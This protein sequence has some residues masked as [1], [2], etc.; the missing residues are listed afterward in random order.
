MSTLQT[1]EYCTVEWLWNDSNIRVTRPIQ[2]DDFQKGSYAEVV[3]TLTQLGSEGWEV[4][5]CAGTANWLFW[6]LKRS[7]Q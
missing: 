2:S 7:T 6:T 3:Q 4:A 5:S 1:W